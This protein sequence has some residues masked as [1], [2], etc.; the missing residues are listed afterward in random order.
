MSSLADVARRHLKEKLCVSTFSF[1]SPSKQPS[2]VAVVAVCA[3][4]AVG[5]VGA[6]P[7]GGEVVEFYR[8]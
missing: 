8:S 5:A 4:C 3:V 7:T 2:V 6:R 1:K